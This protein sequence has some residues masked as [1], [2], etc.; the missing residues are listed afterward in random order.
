MSVVQLLCRSCEELLSFRLLKSE[1]PE[2]EQFKIN[3]RK[4]EMLKKTITFKDLDGNDVT[5][6][7]YFN[8][9]KAEIAEIELSYDGGLSTQLERIIAKK[10]GGEII[11]T[12]KD[13]MLRS[14]GRRS[15]D[16]RRFIKSQDITNEFVQTEAYSE[17]FMELVTNAD[18]AA[19]FVRSIMPQSISEKLENVELPSGDGTEDDRPAWIRENREPNP[20]ELSTMSQAQLV[21]A[22]KAKQARLEG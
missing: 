14:V 19:E 1:R 22:F 11:S 21:E 5:E 12:F 7:F 15:D 20:K 16:G 17:M 10:D 6:D 4:A 3:F 2:Q 13:I 9:N 8:L 18:A